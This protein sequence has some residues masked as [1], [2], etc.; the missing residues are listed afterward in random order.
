M[1]AT[2]PRQDGCERSAATSVGVSF[3]TSCKKGHHGLLA[4]SGL[5]RLLDSESDTAHH[6]QLSVPL[7]LGSA[8]RAERAGRSRRHPDIGP[9]PM[10]ALGQPVRRIGI[11]RLRTVSPNPTHL[12]A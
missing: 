12:P 4:L 7:R 8:G 1:V 9:E 3:T 10:T 2:N 5:N 6:A 11:G